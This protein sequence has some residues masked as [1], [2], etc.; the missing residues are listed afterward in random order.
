M[1]LYYRDITRFK[2]QVTL[3]YKHQ[4]DILKCEASAPLIYLDN[5]G[6][7]T[8]FGGYLWDGASGPT[9]D[10]KSSM[11]G[12]LTHDVFYELFRRGKLEQKYRPYAD[13]LLHD[14]CVEDGMNPIRADIWETMV[15]K[16]AASAARFGTQPEDTVICVGKEVG[17]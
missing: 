12:S 1:K 10:T 6:L 7:L 11:R 17:P 3:T 15:N 16:F 9:L 8:V 5:D 2:Y 13:Q 14:I 4:T